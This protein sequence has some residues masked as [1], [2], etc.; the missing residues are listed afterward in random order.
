[1]RRNKISVSPLVFNCSIQLTH[2][3]EYAAFHNYRLVGCSIAW[4]PYY[5]NDLCPRELSVRASGMDWDRNGPEQSSGKDFGD[6]NGIIIKIWKFCISFIV[7]GFLPSVSI[8]T[9]C[10]T[11]CLRDVAESAEVKIFFFWGGGDDALLRW[12]TYIHSNT[13]PWYEHQMHDFQLEKHQKT[14]SGRAPPGPAGS[15]SAPGPL[16][17]KMGKEKGGARERPLPRLFRSLREAKKLGSAEAPLP[18]DGVVHGW[19]LEI[20]PSPRVLS[21]RVK[22]CQFPLT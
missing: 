18:C 10:T 22:I 16:N 5:M 17:A 15:L 8:W 9:W 6:R 11:E 7:C 1:M 13:S 4:C 20:R 19:P 12:I 21:C 14:F 3:W 2:F